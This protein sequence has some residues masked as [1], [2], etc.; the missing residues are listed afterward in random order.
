MTDDLLDA[1]R[2][3]TGKIALQRSA[4]D[5]G[6]ATAECL[7]ALRTNDLTIQQRIIQS[8]E[9][10]WVDADPTRIEQIVMNLVGNALKYTPGIG[11][12]ESQCVKWERMRSYASLTMA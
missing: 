5:L 2:A 12:V 6:R 1:S 9:S 4:L 11:T 3:M 10:V 8:L 7:F